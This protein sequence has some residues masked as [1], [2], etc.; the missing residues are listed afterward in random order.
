MK[1]IHI[2]F[3]SV[4]IPVVVAAQDVVSSAGG[5]ADGVSWTLGEV[6]TETFV[7]PADVTPALA[8]VQGFNQPVAGDVM[9]MDAVAIR[10]SVAVYPNPVVDL[11][12]IAGEAGATYRWLLSTLDGKSL[13]GGQGAEVDFTRCQAGTYLLCLDDGRREQT[14]VIIKK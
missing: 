14:F 13:G 5:C 11:L 8:V 7:T 1:S 6:V 2:V 4:L 10:P 3:L 12:H 9:G